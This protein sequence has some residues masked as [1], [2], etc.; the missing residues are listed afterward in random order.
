MRVSPHLV[1]LG[2]S[3]VAIS[4]EPGTTTSA[5]S[6]TMTF[7]G[8]P[9]AFSIAESFESHAS[10]A[11]RREAHSTWALRPIFATSPGIG[12]STGVSTATPIYGETMLFRFDMSDKQ[13][14]V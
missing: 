9:D 11:E 8:G 13:T 14:A 1:T 7:P 5:P 4:L 10:T 6:C 12:N 3:P 2:R